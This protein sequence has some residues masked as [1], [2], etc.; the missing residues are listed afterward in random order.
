MLIERIVFNSNGR[1]FNNKWNFVK[2]NYGALFFRVNIVQKNFAGAIIYFRR[3]RNWS[4]GKISN[5]GELN[6]CCY[7]DAR[8]NK[9]Y[10]DNTGTRYYYRNHFFEIFFLVS[11]PSY[12]M[13]SFLFVVE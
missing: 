13:G 2:W 5:I 10:H 7:H 4:F 1:V 9:H 11:H 8:N 12:Y 3:L 6:L